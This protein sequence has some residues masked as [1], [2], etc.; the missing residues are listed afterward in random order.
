MSENIIYATLELARDY[1]F[2]VMFIA[3]RNQINAEKLGGGYVL[4]GNPKR[5]VETI[6]KIASQVGF[7]GI[8]FICR[9]HGR[10]IT[11]EKKNFLN[12]RL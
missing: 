2:P 3:S 1:D 7:D 8:L 4:D 6:N 10:E 11:R 12:K 5:F 9:D